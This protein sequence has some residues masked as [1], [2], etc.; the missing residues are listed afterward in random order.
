MPIDSEM[1]H[2]TSC[3]WGAQIATA[4]LTEHIWSSKTETHSSAVSRMRVFGDPPLKEARMIIV[5]AEGAIEG[6][7]GEFE[8]MQCSQTTKESRKTTRI[9]IN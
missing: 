6:K 8:G 3:R 4:S 5:S 1:E 7:L 9:K 2:R